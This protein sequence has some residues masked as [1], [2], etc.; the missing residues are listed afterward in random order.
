MSWARRFRPP[1]AL[2]DG[3]KLVTLADAHRLILGLPEGRR[4][5]HHWRQTGDLLM[6]A[7]TRGGQFTFAQTLAQLPRALRAEGLI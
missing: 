2:N 6:K 4:Q 7:A 1:I 3:R 5:S